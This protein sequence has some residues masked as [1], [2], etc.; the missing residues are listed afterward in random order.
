MN[1][2][3]RIGVTLTQ[4]CTLS[5]GETAMDVLSETI[6][7]NH[8]ID[9]DPTLLKTEDPL[10]LTAVSDL[11]K[12]LKAAVKSVIDAGDFPLVF[13]GDHAL[14]IGSIAGATQGSDQAVLWIDAHGDCNTHLSSISKRIHGMPLAVVQGQGHPNLTA[15]IDQPI[16][17]QNI[18][19]AGIRS[20]DPEEEA[21]MKAWGN[22]FITMEE[23]RQKGSAWLQEE[24]LGFMRSHA[25]VHLSYDLDSMDPQAIRGVNTPVQGGFTPEEILPLLDSLLKEPNLTSMDIV[26]FNPKN[27]DGSTLDLIHSIHRLFSHDREETL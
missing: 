21:L 13:G 2:T 22:R 7:F 17:P 27:D 16:L 5:G 26:E 24:L 10:Y 4:G 15:L 9:I 18:L 20:L 6:P 14:A 19:L 8:R 23:I 11:A 3:Q 1:K 12:R 25:R